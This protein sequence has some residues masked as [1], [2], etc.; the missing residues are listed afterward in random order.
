MREEEDQIGMFSRVGK[1][2][3]IVEER[4]AG[5]SARTGEQRVERK[6]HEP[7]R[8]IKANFKLDSSF[9]TVS[10]YQRQ[11]VL[12][13]KD[14]SVPVG[15]YRPK[16]SF[17]QCSRHT[18]SEF[19]R[20]ESCLSQGQRLMIKVKMCNRIFR[21]LKTSENS[22]LR[23][24]SQNLRKKLNNLKK[25]SKR[26]KLYQNTDRASSNKVSKL[27]ISTVN[28][29]HISEE[30]SS[31]KLVMPRNVS[32]CNKKGSVPFESTRMFLVK[33]QLSHKKLTSK[34]TLSIFP[35]KEIS[36]L[37]GPFEIEDSLRSQS[38]KSRGKSLFKVPII[39]TGRSP[40]TKFNRQKSGFS[41]PV[42]PCKEKLYRIIKKKNKEGALE[43]VPKF[44]ISQEIQKRSNMI[45]SFDTTLGRE[46]ANYLQQK[47]L[48]DKGRLEKFDPKY[49]TQVRK[50]PSVDYS[51]M[52]GRDNVFESTCFTPDYYDSP[53]HKNSNKELNKSQNVV[54]GNV[55]FTKQIS[56]DSCSSFYRHRRDISPE[57][58]SYNL[59]SVSSC[60]RGTDW[61][62]QSSRTKKVIQ[63][64]KRKILTLYCTTSVKMKKLGQK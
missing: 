25:N 28:S 19:C 39:L 23:G 9:K 31:A 64:K 8:K 6:K 17:I 49:N 1:T 36:L 37:Q 63:E 48:F 54:I 15:Y 18:E 13:K 38:K 34:K 59:D 57:F 10:R 3:A 61:S 35:P 21:S 30:A 5:K 26:E 32:T 53:D 50:I 42:G 20:T 16:F 7:K 40:Q 14:I 56:R 4:R 62:K 60:L 43:I 47:Q 29:Q 12:D 2:A 52:I 51:K 46:E 58:Y 55:D 27:M 24:R 22:S 11:K 45:R 41:K 44:D 33:S